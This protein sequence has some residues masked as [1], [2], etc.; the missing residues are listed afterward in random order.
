MLVKDNRIN[1]L[2]ENKKLENSFLILSNNNNNQKKEIYNKVIFD[3]NFDPGSLSLSIKNDSQN[4]NQNYLTKI[5][6][7]F[8][9]NKT[10][11]KNNIEEGGL[12]NKKVKKKRFRIR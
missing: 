5:Y 9:K 6:S 10:K 3:D 12:I 2:K 1:L 7:N 8:L 4:E 11:N